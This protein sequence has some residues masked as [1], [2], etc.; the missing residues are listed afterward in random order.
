VQRAVLLVAVVVLVLGIAAAAFEP[1]KQHRT[2][3]QAPSAAPTSSSVGAVAPTR[4]AQVVGPVSRF[5]ASRLSGFDQVGFRL[6]TAGAPSSGDPLHCALLAQTTAQQNQGLMGRRDL[7][8]YDGMVFAW[9]NPTQTAFYMQNTL[10]PLSIAWFGSS[11]SFIFSTTMQPCPPTTVQ[12]PLYGPGAPYQYAIEVAGGRLSG[13][14]IVPG[15]SLQL[16]PSC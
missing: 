7:D 4:P 2:A 13:L 8:G 16:S 10:I 15:S 14:G 5:Q 3:G 11:G 1:S 6:T 12:C 9:S